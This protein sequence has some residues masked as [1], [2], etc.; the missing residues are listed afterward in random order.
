VQRGDPAK[1]AEAVLRITAEPD[2]PARLLL[3]SDAVWLASQIAS[4]R[5]A[6]DAAWQ[7]LSLSTDRDGLPDF[8]ATEVARMVR[9][10][11]I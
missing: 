7:D 10:N 2:P 9:P 1:I 4:A 11:R 3:G 5:A 8:T 6:E